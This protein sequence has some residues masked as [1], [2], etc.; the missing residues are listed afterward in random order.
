MNVDVLNID[1]R[2]KDEKQ[3][4]SESFR[5]MQQLLEFKELIA[6]RIGGNQS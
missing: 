1:I 5:F 4:K 3:E 6:E 2:V